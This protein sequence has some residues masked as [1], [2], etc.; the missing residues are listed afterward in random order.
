MQTRTAVAMLTED[1]M[2]MRYLVDWVV[3]SINKAALKEYV[4]RF[5]VDT[6]LKNTGR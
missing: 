5:S 6:H 1:D 4:E 2:P 3:S